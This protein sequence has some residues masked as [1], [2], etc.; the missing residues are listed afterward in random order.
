MVLKSVTSGIKIRNM[1]N[2]VEYERMSEHASQTRKSSQRSGLMRF[3]EF[4]KTKSYPSH[5]EISEDLACSF[6]IY[7]EFATFLSSRNLK[8]GTAKQYFSD[9][10]TFFKKKFREN[11]FWKLSRTDDLFM[12]VIKK[13]ERKMNRESIMNAEVIQTKANPVFISDLREGCRIPLNQNNEK[14]IRQR[15]YLTL[16]FCAVGRGGELS[17]TTW[18]GIRWI[19]EYG[20]L[21]WD[22]SETKTESPRVFLCFAVI[23]NTLQIQ[24]THLLVILWYLEFRTL[25]I[26]YFQNLAILISHPLRYHLY[27]R[28]LGLTMK[29]LWILLVTL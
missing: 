26:G 28:K 19:Q 1:S 2:T 14:S 5:N 27:S 24:Y 22:W 21:F 8:A 17:K 6:V 11:D 16:I 10:K 25:K 18:K 3:D 23:E 9:T 13:M 29:D 12:N 4:L 15:A 7:D 20:A